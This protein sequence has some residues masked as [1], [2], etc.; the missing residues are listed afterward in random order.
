MFQENEESN[1]DKNIYYHVSER[2]IV[3]RFAHYLQ[4][5]I[6]E[7]SE[8]LFIDYHL[9]CEYNRNI[10]RVKQLPKSSNK[11]IPDVILHKRGN[12]KNNFAV[13]EFK[14]CWSKM[15][16]DYDKLKIIELT[17]KGNGEQKSE[18]GKEK[19]FY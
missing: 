14:V 7:D 10:A 3:F 13:M 9:D 4:N 8:K 1:S 5:I 11:F 18:K 2:A 17:K 16:I 12:N 19:W 15:P 6:N